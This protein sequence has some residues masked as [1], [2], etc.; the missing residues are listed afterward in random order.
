M[1]VEFKWEG[2]DDS[3]GLWKDGKRIATAGQLERAG[4]GL[5]YMLTMSD[6][7]LELAAKKLQRADAATAKR[8]MKPTPRMEDYL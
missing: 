2:N 4:Y 3:D 8:N 7:Q 6:Q 1:T 5:D